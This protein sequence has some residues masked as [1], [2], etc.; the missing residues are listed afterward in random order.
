MLVASKYRVIDSMIPPQKRMGNYRSVPAPFCLDWLLLSV[1]HPD[2]P[3][4]FMLVPLSD[5]T[6]VFAAE[7]ATNPPVD[8]PTAPPP[9]DIQAANE[10]A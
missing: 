5:V 7:F 10:S 4:K 1:P 9:E 3:G 6:L 8:L 2:Q